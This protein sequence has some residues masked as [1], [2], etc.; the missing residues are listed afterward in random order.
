LAIS[1]G[2]FVWRDISVAAASSAASG[3]GL[4]GRSISKQASIPS[5]ALAQIASIR[6]RFDPN[7]CTSVAAERP[8][9][10]ATA[11]SVSRVGPRRDM[12]RAAAPRMCS[13]GTVRGLGLMA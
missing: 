11:A 9:S 3:D 8:A 12:A 6:P 10:V 1:S 5:S 13:S 7:R 2:L 4:A